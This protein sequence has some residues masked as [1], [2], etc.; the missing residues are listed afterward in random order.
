MLRVFSSLVVI[1]GHLGILSI[2]QFLQPCKYDWQDEWAYITSLDIKCITKSNPYNPISWPPLSQQT[3]HTICRWYNRNGHNYKWYAQRT[4]YPLWGH[5][6]VLLSQ[7]FTVLTYQDEDGDCSNLTQ[8]ILG[9]LGLSCVDPLISI[10]F[11][12]KYSPCIFI[13]IDL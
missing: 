2:H 4:P 11:F 3:S 12:N 5:M 10:F 8:L 13:F 1:W 7:C 9:L 6:N